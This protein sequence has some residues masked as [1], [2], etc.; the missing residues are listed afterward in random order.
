PGVPVKRRVFLV[1]RVLIFADRATFFSNMDDL[2]LRK[3]NNS[4]SARG[5]IVMVPVHNR[6]SNEDMQRQ[7]N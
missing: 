2:P 4:T 1:N 3:R 6:Y 7:Q 5:G